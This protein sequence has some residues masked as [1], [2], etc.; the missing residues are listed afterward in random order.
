MSQ[1]DIIENYSEFFV[2]SNNILIMY[3]IK[4]SIEAFSQIIL[5]FKE[6]LISS[7]QSLLIQI[8]NIKYNKYVGTTFLFNP[9]LYQ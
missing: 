2:I 8:F 1:I 4:M 6:L 9:H 7:F 5:E 3:I